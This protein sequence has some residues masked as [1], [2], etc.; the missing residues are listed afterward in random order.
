VTEVEDAWARVP[1]QSEAVSALRAA[2]ANPVHAYL[3]RGPRGCGKRAAASVFAAALISEQADVTTAART[4]NLALAEQHPDVVIFEPEGRALR[5]EE[6]AG[7]VAEA[8]RSPIEGAR[9]VIICDRFHTAESAVAPRLLKTIEE[10]PDSVIFVLLAEEVPVEQ[11]TVASRCVIIDFH[12]LTF[13]DM[14]AAL[15]GDGTESNV[16]RTVA[17]ASLGDLARARRLAADPSAAA[18]Q[19]LWYGIPDRLDDT[20]HTVSLVVDEIRAGIDEASESVDQTHETQREELAEREEA[21]GARGSGRKLIEAR[22]KRE[23]RVVR[24]DEL[25][26]GLAALARRYRDLRRDEVLND[27]A[28][29]EASSRIAEM[30]EWLTRNPNETLVLQALLAALPAINTPNSET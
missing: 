29:C 17:E 28:F 8:S 6:A 26:L 12:P 14:V 15:V 1:G 7:M 22:H 13:D 5:V 10:P 24:D 19:A 9:K 25:R 23:L 20:G 3:F 21:Y 4:V 27:G 18:R 2:V 16:A 30:G 11:V